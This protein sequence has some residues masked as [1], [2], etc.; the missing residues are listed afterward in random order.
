MQALF[1]R[2]LSQCRGA[3]NWYLR[4]Q[5]PV[6]FHISPAPYSLLWKSEWNRG[7]QTASKTIYVKSYNQDP[8]DSRVLDCDWNQDA[9]RA[10]LHRP[11]WFRARF[12]GRTMGKGRC[13][14]GITQSWQQDRKLPVSVSHRHWLNPVQAFCREA[15]M[16]GCLSHK[17]VLDFLGIYQDER[18]EQFFLVSP[19][20]KNGTL[21]Q[22]RK[23]ANP[24]VTEV[25]KRVRLSVLLLFVDIHSVR[26]ILEVAQG[27]EY[28]HSEGV[29]H[30]D[31]RGVLYLNHNTLRYW[32]YFAGQCPVGW[33]PSCSNC[34]LWINPT[35]GIYEYQVWLATFQLCSPRAIWILRGWWY[36]RRWQ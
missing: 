14:E 13:F 23:Y 18:M 19:Y 27:L 29:V 35:L 34:R 15:L 24:S 4:R 1:Q 33:W 16:W 5:E 20:M 8:C 6:E 10:R 12:Q 31:L 30:G 32:P 25:E 21:A 26:K 11:R 36:R 22:W 9:G 3:A 2:R 28:I 7:Y 17:F